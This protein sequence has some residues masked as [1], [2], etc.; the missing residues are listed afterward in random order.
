[1]FENSTKHSVI[2]FYMHFF[3]IKGPDRLSDRLRN[4]IRFAIDTREMPL[5]DVASPCKRVIKFLH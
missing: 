3:L 5:F 2:K 4:I 1:M